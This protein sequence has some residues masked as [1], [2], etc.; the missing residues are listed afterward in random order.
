MM[1][2]I[3]HRVVKGLLTARPREG[4]ESVNLEEKLLESYTNEGQMNQE[5]LS[6][7]QVNMLIHT[8]LSAGSPVVPIG[9]SEGVRVI[10]ASTESDTVL[11]A[12]TE[13]NAPCPCGS[14]KKYKQ[15]HGK[16]L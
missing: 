15:C 1:G 9:T 8:P 7:E 6:D 13:R 14:G 10:R 11:Y 2:T 3:E 5:R 12:G 4:I 16:T